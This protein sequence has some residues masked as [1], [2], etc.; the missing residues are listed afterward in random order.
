M[1]VK[2]ITAI[3]LSIVM[4]LSCVMTTSAVNDFNG[5]L[6]SE[7]DNPSVLKIT[8]LS[9]ELSDMTVLAVPSSIRGKAVVKIDRSAFSR[10]ANVQGFAFSNNLLTISD[11]AMF[12][13]P[14]L[15]EITLPK[16]ISS[17]GRSAFASCTA[18]KNVT[19]YT[20]NLSVI[21]KYT[22]FNCPALESVVLSKSVFQLEERCFANCPGLQKIYIP[23]SVSNIDNTVFENS[24]NVTIY[25]VE[26][27][28]AYLY[29]QG[30]N[31]PFVCIDQLDYTQM[32]N[33][34]ADIKIMTF[35][36]SANFYTADTFGNLMTT[37]EI[38]QNVRNNILSSQTDIDN[39]TAQLQN[40]RQSLVLDNIADLQ[41]T[42]T[43]AEN[44]ENCLYQYTVPTAENFQNALNN[45]R[46]TLYSDNKTYYQVQNT[47]DRLNTC[48]NALETVMKGDVNGDRHIRL[49][50]AVLIQRYLL[51]MTSFDN[52]MF[53]CADFNNDGTVTLSDIILIQHYIIQN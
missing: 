13:M 24:E 9:A 31:I 52:R 45:A 51:G 22:F 12:A 34:L 3:L 29:A 18:L 38:A 5:L 39:I 23:A 30:K 6:Y 11:N 26:N 50:D 47:I 15:L 37:Y 17:V 42:I 21:R 43:I 19:F 8:G 41:Q 28:M 16:N 44:Y 14:D 35:D 25:G 33:L 27:S 40:S 32:D 46:N 49:Q 7:D 53:Y 4:L 20:E 48:I 36:G 1:K 10:K 2:N